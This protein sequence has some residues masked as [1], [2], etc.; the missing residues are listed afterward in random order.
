MLNLSSSEAPQFVKYAQELTE[1][2]KELG[3]NPIK[4]AKTKLAA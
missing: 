4:S 2:I 1:T 3:P